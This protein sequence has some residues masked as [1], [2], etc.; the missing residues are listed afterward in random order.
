MHGKRLSPVPCGLDDWA[1]AHIEHL[2][3]HVQFAEPAFHKTQRVI[4]PR[5][6]CLGLPECLETQNLR[7]QGRRGH[8][9]NRR[10]KRETVRQFETHVMDTLKGAV[11][12]TSSINQLSARVRDRRWGRESSVDSASTKQE[13]Y[14]TFPLQDLGKGCNHHVN[15]LSLPTLCPDECHH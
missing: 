15:P 3:H 14:H 1:G 4:F 10:G 13:N 12:S 11:F 7:V 5:I 8:K 9:E 2:P 6:S